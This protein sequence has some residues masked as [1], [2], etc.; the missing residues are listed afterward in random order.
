MK[1]LIP[2]SLTL[3]FLAQPY[4]SISQ[5]DYLTQLENRKKVTA[6][7]DKLHLT[8]IIDSVVIG[9]KTYKLGTK[10]D[11]DLE[12]ESDYLQVKDNFYLK[13]FIAR[14]QEYGSKFYS[15]KWD[16]INKLNT[17]FH[18]MQT[19]NSSAM[20][21][22]SDARLKGSPNGQGIGVEGES[23]YYMIWYRYKLE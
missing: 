7:K 14:N 12:Y 4:L 13:I 22:N 18:T 19:S 5:S 16:Y 21:F 20:D 11:L 9:T 3:V 8:F 1:R 23:Y 15:W 2:F 6:F 10:Y 17:G